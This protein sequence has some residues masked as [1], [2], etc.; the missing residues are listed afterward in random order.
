MN[1]DE[2]EEEEEEATE[3][4][5]E[6]LD[7]VTMILTLEISFLV[8]LLIIYN[9]IVFRLKK[10]AANSS[11]K[12]IENTVLSNSEAS[13]RANSSIN[14]NYNHNYNINGVGQGLP[15]VISQSTN[16]DQV[17]DVVGTLKNDHI[18]NAN[19]NYNYNHNH[20]DTV[21]DRDKAMVWQL[22]LQWAFSNPRRRK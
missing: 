7:V 1:L 10:Q 3:D 4:E 11:R 2:E 17:S 13:T 14:R 21:D 8:C 18:Y 20:S 6:E 19:H 12:N 5:K 22:T 9:I 16:N 15:R